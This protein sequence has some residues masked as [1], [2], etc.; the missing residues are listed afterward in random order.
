MPSRKLIVISETGVLLLGVARTK[1]GMELS[2]AGAD[3][4]RFRATS[5]RDRQIL[6][7]AQA[8]G[9]L[10]LIT[11]DVDDFAEIDL[12]NAGVSAVNPDLFLSV[13]TSSA[14]YLQALDIMSAAMNNPSRTPQELHVR[15][16]RQHP[17][18]VAAH[19]AMF[20]AMPLPAVNNPPSVVF[21]GNTCLSCLDERKHLLGGSCDNCHTAIP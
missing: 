15:L 1:A 3:A 14:G 20:D 17:L 10:F 12:A 11:E 4:E 2:A 19:A 8:S 6:A 13:R 21:R 16:G 18:L 9:A 7:D 5:L